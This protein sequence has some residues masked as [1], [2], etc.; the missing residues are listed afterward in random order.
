MRRE[1]SWWAD[2]APD[3]RP[4]PGRAHGFLPT[5]GLAGLR[6]APPRAGSTWDR[7]AMASAEIRAAIT[8]STRVAEELPEPDR[9]LHLSVAH[10]LQAAARDVKNRR[11]SRTRIRRSS[12]SLLPRRR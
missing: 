9:S 12:K 2:V 8:A 10:I 3:R 4:L 6:G 1:A 11:I 5:A 7:G